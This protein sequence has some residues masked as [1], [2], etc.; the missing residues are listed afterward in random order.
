[1]R[2]AFG[3]EMMCFCFE[4]WM[5]RVEW[6]GLGMCVVIGAIGVVCWWCGR[7]VMK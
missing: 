3:G 7:S 6:S 5:V 1:M 2:G 4:M